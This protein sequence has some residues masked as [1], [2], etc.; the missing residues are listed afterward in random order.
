[1]N[2]IKIDNPQIIDEIKQLSQKQ[3]VL[4]FKHSTRCSISATALNRL[5]RNW[6]EEEMQGKIKAYYLDLIHFRDISNQVVAEFG[7]AHESPQVILIE[8]GKAIY[9]TSHLDINYQELKNL[10]SV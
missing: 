1:M 5:E 6:K 8:N 2:W 7:V 3:K 9:H 10:T 4:I